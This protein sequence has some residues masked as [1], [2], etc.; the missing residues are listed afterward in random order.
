[1]SSQFDQSRSGQPSPES[2]KVPKSTSRAATF[3]M[4]EWAEAFAQVAAI[5]IFNAPNSKVAVARN[6]SEFISQIWVERVLV[7]KSS[8]PVLATILINNE[9]KVTGLKYCGHTDD[10]DASH[11]CHLTEDTSGKITDRVILPR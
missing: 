1:M 11:E 10:C 8:V 5:N 9:N 6:G 7:G 4:F 2:P 3:R